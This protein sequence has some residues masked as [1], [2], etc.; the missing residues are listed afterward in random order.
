MLAGCPRLLVVTYFCPGDF[1][2]GRYIGV[3]AIT[4]KGHKSQNVVS[5]RGDKSKFL[6]A[7]GSPTIAAPAG[8]ITP[9]Y[10]T[11]QRLGRWS[12]VTTIASA[13]ESKF[14]K[15]IKRCSVTYNSPIDP[16]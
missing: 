7:P 9:T 2:K 16:I 5:H 10:M 11:G 3:Q 12:A 13:N 6:L 8:T 15:Q 1:V 4:L 14:T